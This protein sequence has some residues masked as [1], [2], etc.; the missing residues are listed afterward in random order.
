MIAQTPEPPY[1]AVIFTSIRTSIDQGYEEMAKRMVE[2]ACQQPGFLGVESAREEI[3][4]TVSYWKDLESIKNWKHNSEHSFARKKGRKDWYKSFRIR[5][6]KVEKDY[7][8]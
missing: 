6:A 7:G 1:Y 2:L 3:G 4:I 8:M 5:I